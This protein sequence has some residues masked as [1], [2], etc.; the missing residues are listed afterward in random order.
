MATEVT[1]SPEDLQHAKQ[2]HERI[3]EPGVVVI[4][5]ASGDLTKRKLLPALFHLQQAGLLPDEFAIV[6]VARRPLEK[7]FAADMKDG[8][9]K[10]GGV[11]EGDATVD[12]FIEKVS[13]FALNFDDSD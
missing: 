13:Y 9:L 12:A 10:F 3:P 1:I 8:I 5:G 4:F 6:G 7:E 11:K 2:V